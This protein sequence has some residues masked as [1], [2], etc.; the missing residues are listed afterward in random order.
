MGCRNW[1][2]GPRMAQKWSKMI[3]MPKKCIK[4]SYLANYYTNFIHFEM[5]G[6]IWTKMIEM[7]KICRNGCSAH[8]Y[9][10]CHKKGT[11]KTNKKGQTWQ[12]CQHSKVV[13]RG[14]KWS[15]GI[16]KGPKWSIKMVL[17][18]LDLFW[19]RLDLFGPF[20]SIQMFF[21]LKSTSA[22]PYFVLMR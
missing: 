6:Q 22:Q 21:L 1:N 9:T 7:A 12:A 17:T 4:S 5:P 14:P 15:K 13:Q 11:N 18:I 20:Q 8:T 16:Q 19:V 2:L 10:G 3:Q